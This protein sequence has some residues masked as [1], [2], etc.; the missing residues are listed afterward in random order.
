MLEDIKTYDIQGLVRIQPRVFQDERGFFLESYN[1][2]DYHEAGI[3]H[4]FVQDNHSKSARWTLRG[5]HYQ[6]RQPQAK[7]VRAIK[8]EI[9]DVA[10]D[11]RPGS[12]TFGQW[13]AEIL[14][15]HN[16]YHFF[17]PE[18]FAHGFLVLSETAEVL[19]KC[20]HFYSPPDDR[21]ILWSDPQINIDWPL[22]GQPILS[23]KDRA[24]PLLK[25]IRFD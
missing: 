23:K 3:P 5:L 6:A 25:E 14:S 1:Q 12:P 18:G 4:E 15:E 9:F 8:G 10:V 11:I 21:G 20:S 22:E 2:R 24:Q 7:L 17:V 16:H 13:R 19:Y